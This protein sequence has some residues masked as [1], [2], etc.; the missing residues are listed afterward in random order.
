MS[1]RTY[2]PSKIKR[3]RCHGF[4]NRMQSTR[5]QGR[6]R[7]PQ[8]QGPKE[9]DREPLAQV[10]AHRPGS[11][12]K[13]LVEGATKAPAAPPAAGAFVASGV[14][15]FPQPFRRAFWPIVDLTKSSEKLNVYAD[16]RS[17]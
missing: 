12:C 5:R 10:L 8:V 7:S 16:V 11:S 3:R 14:P 1:K 13:L 17:F 9:V 2:Q 6:A 15:T 4:R